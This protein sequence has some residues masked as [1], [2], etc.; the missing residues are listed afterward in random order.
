MDVNFWF[1]NA[2]KSSLIS[3]QLEELH[4]LNYNKW[5]NNLQILTKESLFLR[6]LKLL[7]S[8]YVSSSS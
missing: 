2:G 6:F 1:G 4:K 8:I 5:L 7:S 3:L